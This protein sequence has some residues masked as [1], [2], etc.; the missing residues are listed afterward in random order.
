MRGLFARLIE[1]VAWVTPAR[2]AIDFMVT[3]LLI[4]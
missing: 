4:A 1:T 2:T 3:P